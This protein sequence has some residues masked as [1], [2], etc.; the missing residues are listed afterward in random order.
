MKNDQIRKIIEASPYAGAV[1]YDEDQDNY[2]FNLIE[3]VD[4][5]PNTVVTCRVAPFDSYGTDCAMSS[6]HPRSELTL[7]RGDGYAS[8]NFALCTFFG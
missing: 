1:T 5:I 7:F 2:I 6:C 3:M 4:T 8:L